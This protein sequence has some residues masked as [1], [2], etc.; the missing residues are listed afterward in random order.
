MIHM[1]MMRYLSPIRGL[2]T[3]EIRPGHILGMES[4]ACGVEPYNLF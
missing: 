1:I 2:F 4:I 3:F